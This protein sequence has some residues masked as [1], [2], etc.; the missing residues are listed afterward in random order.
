MSEEIY[1]YMDWGNAGP[2]CIG[3]LRFE[4]V[5]GREVFSFSGNTAWLAHKEFRMLDPNIGQFE[6]PQYLGE[7]KRNFGLFLD[8]SP[9]R[10]GRMLTKPVQALRSI[11]QRTII[12][13]ISI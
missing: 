6:G 5:R 3:T 10:W 1:V 4:Q 8:S 11:Y 13:L 9:D 7:G 2:E 12:H